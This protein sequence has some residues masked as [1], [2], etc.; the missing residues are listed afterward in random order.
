MEAMACGRA[1]VA[2]DVGDVPFLVEDGKTG[3]VVCR[4]DQASLVERVITL[5]GDSDLN[6]RMGQAGRRKAER[7]FRLE[8]LVSETLEVYR[9]SSWKDN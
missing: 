9:K 4:G 1:V 6:N 7:E 8:R 2:T 3:F 5:I